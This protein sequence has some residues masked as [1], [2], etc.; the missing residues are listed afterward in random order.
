M[1]RILAIAFVLS[2][3]LVSSASADIPLPKDQKYIDPRV[4]FE[5]TD[6]YPD[7]VF[8]LRFLTFTGGP[9]NTPPTLIEVKDSNVFPLG[10]QRRLLNMQML[11]MDRKEFDKR[12]KDSP[13]SKWL[14]DKAEGVLAATVPAPSTVVPASVKEAPINSYRVT[15]TDGKLKV[16]LLEIKK[17]GAAPASN[18]PWALGVVVAVSFAWFG[19]WFARRGRG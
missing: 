7:Q 1:R 5:G 8:Y 17:S 11:A 9:A 10:A 18:S 16:E 6:K 19:L 2:L 12:A 13:P 3:V 14:N 15:L 4:K